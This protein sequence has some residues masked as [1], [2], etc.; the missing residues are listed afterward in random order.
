MTLICTLVGLLLTA[1]APV[2]VANFAG[3]WTFDPAATQAS[4][5]EAKM[6]P[7]AIFSTAFTAEQTA[8]ALT[9]HITLGATTVDATYALDG[10]PSKNVSPP[11]VQNGQPIEV[12]STVKW[13][14][15]HLLITSTSQSPSA[16]GPVDV[17]SVRAMWLDASGRLVIERTGTPVTVVASSRSV[18][19]KK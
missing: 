9:L 1:C 2:P 6:Q 15:E 17:K 8:K 12:T 5:T 3:T 19:V 4:A 14:G 13:E 11:A 16:S 10:S 18:Y 7:V